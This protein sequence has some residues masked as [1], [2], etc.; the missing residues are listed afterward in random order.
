MKIAPG[1]CVSTH[2]QLG[3]AA[4]SLPGL[5]QELLQALVT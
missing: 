4:L 5:M 1:L 2:L 3:T